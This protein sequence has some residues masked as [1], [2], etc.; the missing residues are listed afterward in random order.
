MTVMHPEFDCVRQMM[1]TLCQA[2]DMILNPVFYL[3]KVGDYASVL[4]CLI[5]V[6]LHL[7]AKIKWIEY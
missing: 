2:S 7:A 3:E 1:I 6:V 4:C 5:G